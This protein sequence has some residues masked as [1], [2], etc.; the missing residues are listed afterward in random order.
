MINLGSIARPSPYI[1]QNP[2]GFLFP[3]WLFAFVF[4]HLTGKISH[5]VMQKVRSF[6]WKV[7]REPIFHIIHGTPEIFYSSFGCGNSISRLDH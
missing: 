4:I 5:Y 6:L 1:V 3:M 2:D 7:E